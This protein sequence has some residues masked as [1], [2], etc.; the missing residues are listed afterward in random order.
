MTGFILIQYANS[1]EYEINWAKARKIKG[2]N[3]SDLK[4]GTIENQLVIGL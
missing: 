2:I 4:V 3:C 1:T